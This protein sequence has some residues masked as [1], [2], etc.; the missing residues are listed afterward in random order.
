MSWFDSRSG[1][2]FAENKKIDFFLG[3]CLPSFDSID[4]NYPHKIILRPKRDAGTR[5]FST[6]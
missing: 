4:V 5:V 6:R 3:V 2:K 1:V